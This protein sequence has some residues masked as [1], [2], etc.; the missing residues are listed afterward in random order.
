[1]SARWRRPEPTR[2]SS[3][4]T[5]SR[6]T[7]RRLF[8]RFYQP[9][10]DITRLRL[11]RELDLSTRAEMRLPLLWIA[12]L[13]GRVSASL[14]ASTGVEFADDVLKYLLAGADTVMTTSALLRHGVGYM[15]LL[16]DGLVAQLAA[17][18][19]ASVSE[20]RGR[21]SQRNLKNPTAFERANYVEILQGYH[22][23]HAK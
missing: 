16:L 5:S 6:P 19:I 4:C 11:S 22:V 10:I 21:L 8:N 23:P 7:W 15:R 20:I 14:A 18:E 9:D 17:R 1:M 2:S 12:I 13:H 3:T